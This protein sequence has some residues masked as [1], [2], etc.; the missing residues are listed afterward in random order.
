MGCGVR[1]KDSV[2]CRAL[3]KDL[4][5]WTAGYESFQTRAELEEK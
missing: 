5:L 1:N 2:R 3:A 4:S